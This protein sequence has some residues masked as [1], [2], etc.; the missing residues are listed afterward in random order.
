MIS[1]WSVCNATLWFSLCACVLFT[2]RR[3]NNFL[4]RYGAAAWSGAMLLTV[5]RLLLPLDIP[6]MVILRSYHILPKLRRALN[7]SLVNGFSLKQ[8][9]CAVW[10]IGAL[11]GLLLV[12]YGLLRDV[13]R[14]R[15]LACFPPS[16]QLKAA[17]QAC[18][19]PKG[20]VYISPNIQAPATMGLLH[21]A[22]YFPMDD[23]PEAALPC[24][25]KHELC[26]IRRHDAWLRLGFFLFRCLFWWNPVVHFAQ[27]PVED[28][29]EL[30]CDRAALENASTEEQD[31][32]VKAMAYVGNQTRRRSHSFIGAAFFAQP[33]DHEALIQRAQLALKDPHPPRWR[34]ATT[35]TLSLILFVV[36]YLFIWQPAG[37]P[38][39]QNDDSPE[40]FLITPETAYLVESAPGEYQ[41]WCNGV[42]LHTVLV[43][44][45]D[46][47]YYQNLEVRQ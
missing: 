16:A 36:S 5:V 4:M 2:L 7:H 38:P 43:D 15:R 21:P 25:L 3:N 42:F 40:M 41:L 33:H 14:Q 17:A 12:L 47:E 29:L 1:L 32:Y 20:V 8:I 34:V 37:F 27:K 46:K 31:A 19:F 39:S 26:H 10:A 44:E 9:L 45:L 11:I 28:V 23:Y 18:G 24:I 30:R 22:V 6:Y 35:L 13:W